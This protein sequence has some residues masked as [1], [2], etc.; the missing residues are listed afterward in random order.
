MRVIVVIL[1]VLLLVTSAYLVVVLR[2]ISHVRRQLEDRLD[3]GAHSAVTLSLVVPQLEAL[4]ARVNDTVR[5]A[6]ATSTRTREEERRIRFFIADIS[7]DLRTPLTPVRG[8]L[9]LLERTDL[10]EL[11]R[12]RLDVAQRQAAELAALVDRL[13]EYAYLLEVEPT[14]EL[15]TIDVGVL[16]GECLLGM[17]ADIEAAGLDVDYEP[18]AGLTVVTDREKVTRIVQNLVR[19]ATHH[20]RD[21]L[22]SEVLPAGDGVQLRVS[23]GLA[24]GVEVDAARLFER[25]YTGDRSRSRRTSG[26]GLSIVHVLADQLRG[27]ARADQDGNLLTLAVT[28]PSLDRS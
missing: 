11:Q 9:Q 4:A 21:L 13:Y 6:Q 1:A 28:L 2:Q 25:F 10:D 26:L 3:G 22:V 20:G 18:P 12:S 7:H 15:E 17:S 27:Q 19:N 5:Q 14:L 23:N 16:M 24:P 8:Y